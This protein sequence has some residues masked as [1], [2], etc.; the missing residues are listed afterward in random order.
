MAMTTLLRYLLLVALA[1]SASL[2]GRA[3]GDAT[4]HGA[5]AASGHAPGTAFGHAGNPRKVS[6]TISI[7]MSDAM[8]FTPEVVTVEEGETV[9]LRITNNGGIDHEFVLGDEESLRAHAEMMAQMPGM[10]HTDAGM[11]RVPP[12]QSVDIVWTFSRAGEFLFACTVPGHWEAGM[13]GR[14][15]VTAAGR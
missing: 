10:A 6:R 5:H 7:A 13:A 15:R 12:G 9:R 11:V 1:L 14:I 3:V 2:A 8:R 4:G